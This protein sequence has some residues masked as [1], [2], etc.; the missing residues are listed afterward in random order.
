MAS[1]A[2][3]SAKAVRRLRVRHGTGFL[4][5]TKLRFD[6]IGSKPREVRSALHIAAG[7]GSTEVVRALL[8][9]GAALNKKDLSGCSPLHWA[10]ARPDE[11]GFAVAQ[12]LL[13][14]G[15]RDDIEN[16]MGKTPQAWAER[17]G[18]D[19]VAG[20]LKDHRA[21]LDAAATAAAEADARNPFHS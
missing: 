16:E 15:A 19:P 4:N 11:D 12:L 20:L 18:N 10:A 1:R 5:H 21:K 9:G 6:T 7:S 8:D 2:R 13:E 3:S 14:R 17:C